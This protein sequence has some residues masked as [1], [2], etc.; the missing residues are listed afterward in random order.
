LRQIPNALLQTEYV[1]RAGVGDH[2]VPV[3]FIAEKIP[4]QAEGVITANP[5]LLPLKKFKKG[6]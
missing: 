4:G 2:L 3:R 1:L 6:L 5:F